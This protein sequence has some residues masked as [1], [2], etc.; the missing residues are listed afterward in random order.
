MRRRR[1]RAPAALIAKRAG[2]NGAGA[3]AAPP[4]GIQVGAYANAGPAT[5]AT[6]VVRDR[7]PDLLG[8][9]VTRVEGVTR[10]QG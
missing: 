1:C 3:Q 8:Q 10:G 5:R 9:T 2:A 4:W 7:L 6:E